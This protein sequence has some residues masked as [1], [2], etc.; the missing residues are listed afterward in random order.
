MAAPIKIGFLG[1]GM[2]AQ[3]GHLPFYLDDHRCEVAR[4]CESRPSVVA[5]LEQRL[6]SER[7]IKHHDALFGDNEI[8]AIVI[9]VPRP[10]TGP[11]TLDALVAGKHVLAEK[12]M[13]HSLEQAQCLVE[14]ATSR[15]LIYAI[16]FMKRYDPGIQA[17]RALFHEAVAEGRL[18]RL[19]HARFYDFSSSYAVTPPAHVR[20]RES[21]TER[22]PTWPLYPSWLPEQYRS[23][24]AWFLNTASHDV[25][26]LR[27]FFPDG[28]EVVSAHCGGE[29]SVVATMRHEDTTVVLEIAKSAVGR[30]VEGIDFVFERGQIRV[31]IPSPMASE[32]VSE[33][34]LDDERRGIIGERI[35]VGTGWSFARQAAG[36]VDALIGSSGPLTSG[37]DG[38]A[39]MA[40]TEE[41]WQRV[42]A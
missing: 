29:T 8:Q 15:R 13:A 9:S 14:A 6:G 40:L 33:V 7:V 16:G 17:A 31:A 1:G 26:L 41:I 21:R 37:K 35:A 24:F 10:A 27:F 2:M 34:I 22:F 11:L 3:I 25:N 5:A 39:D 12:P 18:G 20:P 4:V 28:V 36:F 32:K 38:L 30:W 19:L 23:T 42:V